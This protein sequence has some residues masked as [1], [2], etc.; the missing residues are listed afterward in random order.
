M[1][2]TS[3]KI[4]GNSPLNITQKNILGDF[5][6]YDE[7]IIIGDYTFKVTKRLLIDYIEPLI[8]MNG[9]LNIF[10]SV[11]KVLHIKNYSDYQ[12]LWLYLLNRQSE[13]V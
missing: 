5:Q 13:V 12:E 10:N 2:Y 4:L 6:D 7:N 9:Y 1:D 11:Y 3:V 8:D